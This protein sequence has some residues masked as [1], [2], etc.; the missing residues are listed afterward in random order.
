LCEIA[1]KT[2]QST[3][4]VRPLSTR[5]VLA[6]AQ[7]LARYGQESLEY[8]ILNSSSDP[9]ERSA[10]AALLVGKFPNILEGY[11]VQTPNTTSP[12]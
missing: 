10:L 11:S 8:T 4:N 2:R 12:F 7:D 1:A 6:A 9:V 3:S 5:R